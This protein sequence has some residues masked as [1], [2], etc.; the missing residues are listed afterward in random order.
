MKGY[1]S[2]RE[3]AN[4]WGISERRVNQYLLQGRIPGSERFGKLWAIPAN[5]SK[6]TDPRRIKYPSSKNAED[7]QQERKR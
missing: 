7:I 4:K 1:V 3:A 5:A 6:P 2:I